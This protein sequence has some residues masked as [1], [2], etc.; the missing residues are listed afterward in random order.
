MA[1]ITDKTPIESGCYFHIYNRG[2]N[3]E[4]I[5]YT[6]KHYLLFISRYNML[7]GDHVETYSYCL[8]PNHFHFMIRIKEAKFPGYEEFISTQ[9]N[10]LFSQHA[11]MINKE[12]GRYGSLF[13]KSF[14]RIKINSDFYLKNLIVYIHKNPSKHR[15]SGNY[16]SYRYSSYGEII[17]RQKKIVRYNDVLSLYGGLAAFIEHHEEEDPLNQFLGKLVIEK[18]HNAE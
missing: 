9:L 4:R 18:S 3:R 6:E 8:L 7:L 14:K 17:R 12:R 10:I 15:F 16:R 2:I 13:C 11:L 5:F 1:C